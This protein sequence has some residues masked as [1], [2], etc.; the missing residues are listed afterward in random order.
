MSRQLVGAVESGRHLPNVHAAIAIAQVLGVAVE[1][2]FAEPTQQVVSIFGDALSASDP[3][4]DQTRDQSRDQSRLSP[5]RPVMSSVVALAQVGESLVA[6]PAQHGVVNA[7]RWALADAM[8]TADGAV[9]ML[10]D[11]QRDGFVIAGC[12]PGLG[13]L[14]DLV[15]RRSRHR[16]LTAHASTGRSIAA[17]AAG[18]VHAVVVHAPAGELPVP[19]I[20]VR[21]WHFARWQ[22]GVTSGR[23]TGVPS[24]SEIAERRLRVVQRD[25]G[26]GT[27]LAF[28]RAL[29]RIGAPAVIRGPVAQGHVDAARR[30]AAG[31][32]AGLT[33]EAAAR[34]FG[35]GF[36]ALEEHE[37]EVW[38]SAQ[39]ASLPAALAVIEM[40]GDSALRSRLSLIGGYDLAAI[41]EEVA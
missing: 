41:A 4:R 6:V 8:V 22:V 17:L 7:E 40:L 3:T 27:Q 32:A 28:T 2:L 30:V 10:A 15:E 24:I 16:I 9:E 1:E 34:S 20:A 31:A 37:V 26:A 5:A 11:A 36:E 21:R 39:W 12:D 29:T 19:P 33:M 23:S 25:P 38:I 13:V 14:A 35:L 18:R